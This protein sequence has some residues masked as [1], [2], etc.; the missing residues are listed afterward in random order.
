[1][2]INFF[3]FVYPKKKKTPEQLLNTPRELKE[4]NTKNKIFPNSVAWGLG[5]KMFLGNN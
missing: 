1:M 3:F 4:E 5:G 2:I